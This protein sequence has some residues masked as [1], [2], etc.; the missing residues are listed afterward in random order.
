MLTLSVYVAF[1]VQE[2]Q[3]AAER[4]QQAQEMGYRAAVE[5]RAQHR[6]IE[7][8]QPES[9][10]SAAEEAANRKA[11]ADRLVKPAPEVK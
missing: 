4:A 3:R 8:V 2:A 11:A 9:H 10:L 5:Q 6:E 1:L 7:R